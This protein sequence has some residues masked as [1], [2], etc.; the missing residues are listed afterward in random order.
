MSI[1]PAARLS[2]LD[3]SIRFEEANLRKMVCKKVFDVGRDWAAIGSSSF[4]Q[5]SLQAR[6]YPNTQSSSAFLTWLHLCY[7]ATTKTYAAG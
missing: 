6:L 3:V 4:L 5:S 7:H 2:T 1:A